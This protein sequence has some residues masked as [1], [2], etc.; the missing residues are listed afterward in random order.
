MKLFAIVASGFFCLAV[1]AAPSDPPKAPKAAPAPAA[2]SI[3][4]YYSC[5]GKDD[6]DGY[7]GVVVIRKHGAVYIVQWVVS[8]GPSYT[9]CGTRIGD[10]FTVGWAMTQ[11]GKTLRGVHNF[12]IEQGKLSGSWASLPGSGQLYAET[13]TFLKGL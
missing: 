1:L 7:E 10:R 5:H 11:D 6:A 4:G 8:G 12:A 2:A 3:E 13:L 9:G